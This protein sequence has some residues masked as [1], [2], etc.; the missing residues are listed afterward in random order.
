MSDLPSES[1]CYELIAE[2]SSPYSGRFRPTQHAASVWG[3]EVQHGGPVAG[4]LTRA[5]DRLA[6]RQGSRISRISVDIFGAIPM[7]PVTVTAWIE[8]PGER[9]ELLMSEM[10]AVTPDGQ[11]RLVARGAAWRLATRAT[12]HV[13]YRSD[14]AIVTGDPDSTKLD[15][16]AAWR[17]GFAASL[18]A[19]LINVVG[20]RGDPTTAWL[21][22][23]Q[24]LISGEEMSYL[25]SAV[26][27]SDVANGIGARLDPVD[28]TF[29]NTDLVLHFFEEPQGWWLGIAAETSIGVDGIGMSA[30]TMHS[31]NGVIGRLAQNILIQPR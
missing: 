24:P 19:Q 22:M 5:M 9:V 6:P 10:R 29:V 20:V 15:W 12:A 23:T 28:W 3:L 4:L 30:A 1:G 26:T 8:R 13:A 17:I 14:S 21:R 7:S 2:S 27:I 18:E 31:E 11:E 16:P 25:E